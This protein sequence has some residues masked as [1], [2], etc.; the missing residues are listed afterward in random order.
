MDIHYFDIY[1]VFRGIPIASKLDKS[2]ET[3]TQLFDS[4][5]L[6]QLCTKYLFAATTKYKAVH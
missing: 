2:D 5:N 6:I 3:S 4:D 1:L